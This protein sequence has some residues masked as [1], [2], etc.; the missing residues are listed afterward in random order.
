MDAHELVIQIDRE[1]AE[2]VTGADVIGPGP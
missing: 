2:A 1:L